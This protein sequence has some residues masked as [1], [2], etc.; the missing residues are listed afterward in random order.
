MFD[1]TVKDGYTRQGGTLIDF[2]VIRSCVM[3]P[4]SFFLIRYYKID[5][6]ADV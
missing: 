5:Y 2:G 4:F 3:L 6:F 1:I